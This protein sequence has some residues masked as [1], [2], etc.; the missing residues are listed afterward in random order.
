MMTSA[1]VISAGRAARAAKSLVHAQTLLNQLRL[2]QVALSQDEFDKLVADAGRTLHSSSAREALNFMQT[3]VHPAVAPST[4]T[5]NTVLKSLS[6]EGRH[7]TVVSTFQHMDSLHLL[8]TR[9]F[10][11]ALDSCGWQGDVARAR[12]LLFDMTRRGIPRSVASY[13][14]AIQACIPSHNMTQAWRFWK[15]MLTTDQLAPTVQVYTHLLSVLAERDASDDDTSMAVLFH[16]AVTTHRLQPTRKMALLVL[17]SLP[18]DALLPWLTSLKQRGLGVGLDGAIYAAAMHVADQTGDVDGAVQCLALYC[19]SRPNTL[20]EHVLPVLRRLHLSPRGTEAVVGFVW[21]RFRASSPHT[22]TFN[23]LLGMLGSVHPKRVTTLLHAMVQS[24]HADM[25]SFRLALVHGPMQDR[26]AVLQS[27]ET[28]ELSKGR[29][30]IVVACNSALHACCLRSQMDIAELLFEYMPVLPNAA[31][32]GILFK[33]YAR[34]PWTNAISDIVRRHYDTMCQD[35]LTPTTSGLFC[36]V[37][38]LRPRDVLPFVR[39]L[40]T[41]ASDM[42][43]VPRDVC[44]SALDV[45]RVHGLWRDAIAL[46]QLMVQIQGVAPTNETHSVVLLACANAGQFEAAMAYL[47]SNISIATTSDPSPSSPLKHAQASIVDVFNAAIHVCAKTNHLD[48]ASTLFYGT[49]TLHTPIANL[50]SFPS[51]IMMLLL[52]LQAQMD[53]PSAAIYRL[54]DM[55]LTPT[56]TTYM[57]Y[58]KL[59]ASAGHIDDARRLLLDLPASTSMDVGVYNALL[60]ACCVRRDVDMAFMVLADL[61]VAAADLTTRLSHKPYNES[62]SSSKLNPNVVTYSHMLHS[63]LQSP[64]HSVGDMQRLL[65]EMIREEGIAPSAVPFTLVMVKC[66][67]ADQPRQAMDVYD[68]MLVQHNVRPDG[69]AFQV[70]L[71]AWK[72]CLEAPPRASDVPVDL[73]AVT[74]HVLDPQWQLLERALDDQQ[75]DASLLVLRVF[76]LFEVMSI[77]RQVNVLDDARAFLDALTALEDDEQEQPIQAAKKKFV[78]VRGDSY[79]VVMRLLNE[80][81]RAAE[82]MAVVDEMNARGTAMTVETYVEWMVALE[83]AERWSDST[84]AFVAMRRAFGTANVSVDQLSRTYIGRQFLRSNSLPTFEH[85]PSPP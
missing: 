42:S 80:G 26:P 16:D 37:Q 21:E 68:A 57:R 23:V 14:G 45:C 2:K 35:Q 39:T 50:S 62:L 75:D 12:L 54:Q 69:V 28:Y 61:K 81:G 82:A 53:L 40:F 18:S 73:H 46:S 31:S 60:R 29:N 44:H 6:R 67:K 48:E 71:D 49:C 72:R 32:Y 3:Q 5:Y 38:C 70:Y 78:L 43:A 34:L 15:T 7:A 74:S 33:G 79:A 30:A 47:H 56:A 51:I 58:I 4:R 36:L 77:T 24:G 66:L 17:K 8:D 13:Q 52:R 63:L 10:D 85:G 55:G 27:L 11:I 20:L 41:S 84:D 76:Q 64:A 22:P 83:A 59:L 25:H 19:T 9:S 1:K 65:R